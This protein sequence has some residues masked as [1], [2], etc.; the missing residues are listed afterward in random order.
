MDGVDLLILQVNHVE[1]LIRL[2]GFRLNKSVSQWTLG[3]EKLVL[4]LL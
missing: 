2:S 4:L 1:K 3:W